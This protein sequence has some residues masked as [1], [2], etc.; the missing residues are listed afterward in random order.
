MQGGL[1]SGCREE[2]IEVELEDFR[3]SINALDEGGFYRRGM[4]GA[5]QD[6]GLHATALGDECVGLWR[7]Q[8]RRRPVSANAGLSGTCSTLLKSSYRLGVMTN[9]PAESQRHKFEHIRD[10][11]TTSSCSY[12]AARSASHKPDPEIFRIGPGALG[13]ATRRGRVH[14][15]PSRP[16]CHRCPAR[17]YAR[18]LVQPGPPSLPE[19]VHQVPDAIVRRLDELPGVI[20]DLRLTDRPSLAADLDQSCDSGG[21]ALLL[22]ATP[23]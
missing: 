15:R 23:E 17:R 10:C 14:R 3:H 18:H 16:G 4:E 1:T 12:P 13:V 11:R 5:I 7:F 2:R 21:V 6:L 19:P 22:M 8:G 20:R 9:G